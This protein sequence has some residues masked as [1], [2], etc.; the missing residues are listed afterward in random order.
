[1]NNP[2]INKIVTRQGVF[3]GEYARNQVH[4]CLE[5]LSGVTDTQKMG[6]LFFFFWYKINTYAVAQTSYVYAQKKK[7]KIGM[8][9]SIFP[10]VFTQSLSFFLSGSL[11]VSLSL[12]GWGAKLVAKTYQLWQLPG[13]GGWH[14]IRSFTVWILTSVP[15]P[16]PQLYQS[17][18]FC[19]SEA[20]VCRTA[21]KQRSHLMD[22]HAD[23][24]MLIAM[25]VPRL[26]DTETGAVIHCTGT[27]FCRMHDRQK[28][29]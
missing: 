19:M 9:E 16:S 25:E 4:L 7:V 26:K 3:K 2:C 13:H 14:Q 18:V 12:R 10:E 28:F 24:L 8:A 23:N 15:L 11:S 1:M 20:S 27:E 5:K 17:A 22:V 29:S 21:W 6:F